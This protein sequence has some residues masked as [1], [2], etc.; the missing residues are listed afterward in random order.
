MPI[1]L[2]GAL[3]YFATGEDA[4]APE[5]YC[6]TNISSQFHVTRGGSGEA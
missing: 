3:I 4:C 1:R 5:A 2:F 6:L